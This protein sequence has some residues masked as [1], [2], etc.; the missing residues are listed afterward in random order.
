MFKVS[1]NKAEYEALLA[2]ME[3]CNV[4]RIKTSQA[5][6]GYQLVVSQVK[7]EYAAQDTT[8]VAY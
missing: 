3:I 2:D 1:N 6:F 4:L 8:I 5:F 7:G